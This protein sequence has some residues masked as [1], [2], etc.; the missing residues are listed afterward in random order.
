MKETKVI[1]KFKTV[2]LSSKKPGSKR[3][4]RLKYWCKRFL[5]NG[6][7]PLCGSGTLGNMSFRMKHNAFIITASAT[8]DP[9]NPDNFVMVKRVDLKKRVVY[10]CGKK[11]PSSESM[12]HYLIYKN[13]DNINAVFHGH[14]KEILKNKLGHPSTKKHEEYGTIQLAK[15]IISALDDHYFLIM[16]EHGFI[17]IGKSMDEAGKKALKVLKMVRSVRP[18]T[19]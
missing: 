19:R 1:P 7:M 18:R 8:K 10:V 11:P 13:K 2:F 9:L 4:V 16:K 17:A 12:M 3:M 15:S 14:S 6:L 5:R